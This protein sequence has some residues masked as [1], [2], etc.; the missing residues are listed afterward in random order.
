MTIH[1]RTI[2]N[3]LPTRENIITGVRPN[4]VSSPRMSRSIRR[5]VN[6]F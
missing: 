5:V 2:K 6:G 1:M 4:N 3:N